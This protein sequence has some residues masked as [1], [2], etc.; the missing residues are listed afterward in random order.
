MLSAEFDVQCG[1]IK[2]ED[3]MTSNEMYLSCG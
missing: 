1:D 3:L 2:G